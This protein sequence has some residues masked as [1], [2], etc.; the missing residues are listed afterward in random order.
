MI[1]PHNRSSCLA[2]KNVGLF[3]ALTCTL[4]L[5][6]S[7]LHGSSL[8]RQDAEALIVRHFGYPCLA[9]HVT[10]CGELDSPVWKG[11]EKLVETGY[12]IPNLNRGF[13]YEPKLVPTEK[14]K[15]YIK[16]GPTFNVLIRDYCMQVY[17]CTVVFKGI[18]VIEVD[19]AQGRARVEYQTALEPVQPFYSLFCADSPAPAC[20]PYTGHKLAE[21]AAYTVVI[22]QTANGWEVAK[23]KSLR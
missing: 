18:T 1:A 23:A 13:Q 12:L 17:V 8:S 6:A 19:E 4:L 14:G 2:T 22:Q 7:S 16:R 9:P 3:I 10:V 20:R 21:T 15:P 5:A 11:F